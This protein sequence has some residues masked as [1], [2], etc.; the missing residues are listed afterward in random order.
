MCVR[1]RGGTRGFFS[2]PRGSPFAHAWCWPTANHSV[3]QNK[4][5]AWKLRSITRAHLLHDLWEASPLRNVTLAYLLLQL[6]LFLLHICKSLNQ[7]S[8]I[9]IEHAHCGRRRAGRLR[10]IIAFKIISND[11]KSMQFLFLL[12]LEILAWR[13]TSSSYPKFWAVHLSSRH[14]QNRW[15][16]KKREKSRIR[17]KKNPI[18]LHTF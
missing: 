6:P 13:V 4:D 18:R 12:L 8:G 7:V 1:V 16:T 15:I 5:S 14:T 10:K 9:I 17:N 11:C 2:A 3:F